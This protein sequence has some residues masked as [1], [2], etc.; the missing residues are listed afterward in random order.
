MAGRLSYTMT[1]RPGDTGRAEIA[2]SVSVVSYRSDLDQL[3]ATLTSLGIAAGRAHAAG[4]LASVVLWV[5][6]N[7]ECDPAALDN[8]VAQAIA[9]HGAWLR[10]E[11]VRGH[12]NV[13]YGQGHN[14]AIARAGGRYHLVLNPDIVVDPEALVEGLRLLEANPDIGMLAPHVRDPSGGRQFLCKRYP[15]V[16]MLGLRG[17]APAWL[18]RPFRARLDHYEM[19]DLREDAPFTPV[20]IASGCFML[21]RAEAL[22]AVGGFSPAYF[23]Y[24]EDFDLSLRLA[25]VATIA[26]APRVRIVHAGGHSAGKGWAHRRMFVRS[27]IAFFR[28]HGWRL[29]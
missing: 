9:P 26:Y 7:G 8:V 14:L 1:E 23:M 27:A 16:L 4:A 21:C 22:A 25:R 5:V 2:L 11:M 17:F 20:P 28:R 6:D 10:S 24:F 18:R 15:S 13:G 3:A 12:G 19:R 29:V